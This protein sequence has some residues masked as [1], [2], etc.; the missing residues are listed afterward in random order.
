MG[1]KGPASSCWLLN[2]CPASQLGIRKS[3]GKLAWGKPLHVQLLAPPSLKSLPW[4][5]SREWGSK[6]KLQRLRAGFAEAFPSL[7]SGPSDLPLL[8]APPIWPRAV[9]GDRGLI[10]GT[11]SLGGVETLPGCLRYSCCFSAAANWHL[12]ACPLPR[13]GRGQAVN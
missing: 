8:P 11:F 9:Q 3:R 12:T 1:L 7:A 6:G 10:G 13:Y 2:H 4:P 5:V